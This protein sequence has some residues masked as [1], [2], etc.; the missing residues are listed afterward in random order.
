MTNRSTIALQL[1]QLFLQQ[2]L[3]VQAGVET[4][5]LEQFRV[6]PA[7][8]DPAFVEHQNQIGLLH[9]EMR[10]LTMTTVRLP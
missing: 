5:L 4:V 1:F 3:P 8:D 10:W 2:L 6:R 9:G 7:L